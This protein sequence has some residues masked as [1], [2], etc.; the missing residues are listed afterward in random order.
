MRELG[1]IKFNKVIK[2]SLLTILE[3]EDDYFDE[4]LL[5]RQM[6]KQRK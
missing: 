6:A 3:L 4:K 2:K 1:K 5:V